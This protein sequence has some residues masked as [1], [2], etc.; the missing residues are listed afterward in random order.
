[1][2]RPSAPDQ[3]ESL[4]AAGEASALSLVD[5]PGTEAQRQALQAV[6]KVAREILS[7]L[8]LESTLLSIVNAA[9]DLLGADI[10]GILLADDD[11]EVLRMR[12]C[13]GH[14]TVRT[15]HLKV[16][17]GEGVAGKVFE[18]GTPYKVDDYLSDTSIS[19]HFRSIAQKDDTRSALGAPMMVGGRVIGTLMVWSRR[20]SAFGPADTDTLINLANLATIAIENARLYEN[21]R[22][23]VRT[24]AEAHRQLEEQYQL[25]QRASNLHNELAQLVLQGQGLS[26][27]VQMMAKHTGGKVAILDPALQVLATSP[28]AE[29]LVDRAQRHLRETR[30][31]REQN[32]QGTAVVPPVPSF[33]HWLMVSDVV[34]GGERLA[35]LCVGL[36]RPPENLDT[37]IVEQAAI[38]CALEL[39]KERAVLE[40]H[41][42]VRSDFLW[43]LLDSNISDD[44]E[45]LVR[46]RYLGYSLPRQLRVMLVPVA[47]LEEWA[48][49]TEASA[50]AVDR[51]RESLVRA[52]ERLAAE[53][54]AGGSFVARRGSLIAL[55]LPCLPATAAAARLGASVLKGLEAANP[56]LAFCAGIS[57]CVPLGVNLHDA[58]LQAQHALSAVPVLASGR[59]VVVF[60]DLGVLRFLLAPADRGEL[61]GFAEKVLGPV[62]DYDRTHHGD[63]LRTLEVYLSRDCNLQRA[64]EQLHVHPKTIRYRL[65]R[66]EGLTGIDFTSQQDRFNAQ[67]AIT[68][69]RALSLSEVKR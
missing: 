31:R 34:A 64:G 41:V 33:D 46:A 9:L 68:I 12:A 38:V 36:R 7:Q 60:D 39:T 25:L 2:G 59:K 32:V 52:A 37:V 62:L 23:A 17:R 27:L 5:A 18:T 11:E 8:D 42:R 47:G 21:E 45:A 53:A 29:L 49:M 48:R 44:A 15:A 19:Q 55:L 1:V 10:V 13:A 54:G 14:R 3:G 63:L 26:E 24:L 67:L 58:Y 16:R 22:T 50:D 61:V 28:G 43:D 57:A 40:A 56:D 35:R 20:P 66:I 51:R 30:R 69:L 4:L 6:A 65:A